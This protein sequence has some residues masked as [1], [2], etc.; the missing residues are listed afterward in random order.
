MAHHTAPWAVPASQKIARNIPLGSRCDSTCRKPN[1]NQAH[2]TV[3]GG[4]FGTV[5]NFDLHRRNGWCINPE[6][7]GLYVNVHGVWTRPMD[8][9]ARERLG[10]LPG[11]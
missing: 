4:T 5:G 11:L 10:I 1:G 8:A 6:D 2:C 9:L 3:C 7:I